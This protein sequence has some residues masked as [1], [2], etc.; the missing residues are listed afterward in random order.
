MD[1]NRESCELLH[2]DAKITEGERAVFNKWDQKVILA[3]ERG[4]FEPY[5]KA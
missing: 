2:S 5:I 4:K 3:C 1:P